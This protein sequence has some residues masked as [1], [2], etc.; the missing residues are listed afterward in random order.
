MGVDRSPEAVETRPAN[1]ERWGWYSIGINVVL[2]AINLVVA[3]A[4]GSL[5]V[6]AELVHNLVDLLTAVAVL[7][8]LRLSTRKTKAFPYG[9]YKLENVITV[10]L[11]MMI[12][13]TAYEIARDALF[14]PPGRA[15]V[16]P[17]MLGGLIVATIIPLLFS[18]FE[19]QAGE[20][21]NSPALVADAKEY[22]AHVFTT[23]VVIA[24]LLAQRF[25]LPLD[26]V[27][28]LVIVVAIGKTGWEL[29]ADGMRVLLDASLD[30][31]TLLQIRQIILQEP[32]VARLAWVTGRNAGRFR[33]VEAELTLRV[34]D[35][36]RA[37]A[38]TR[39]IEGRID[40]AV[41][42]LERVLIHAE[43]VER[44]HLRY[45]AP[46]ADSAG[47]L[48][49]HF[50]EASSFALV[51]VRL[52]DGVITERKTLP[53]PFLNEDKAKGI[54][55]AE[56]L[57]KQRVDVV[58]LKESLGGKG[59]LYVFSDAGVEMRETAAA[60]LEEALEEA[61]KEEVV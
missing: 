40:Q 16:D 15:E 33:F 38:I 35:L 36:E 51:N 37:E 31:D 7:I 18:H 12:F 50:G 59:P 39:R 8:G 52:E 49:K 30:A 60:T 25:S 46:V 42:Y 34:R 41:P 57:V 6:R 58:F 54:R 11:A 48:S 44:T 21:A 27:A 20:R 45:A 22:R 29:L 43:P 47:L 9:L 55:V 19:L 26:R 2:G 13:V 5:A 10:G 23:G 28:A 61:G 32:A 53:N 1:V 3:L 17:W 4:S 24:A 14:T 56:W